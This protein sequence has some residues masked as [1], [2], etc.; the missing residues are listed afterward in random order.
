MGLDEAFDFEWFRLAATSLQRV[1]KFLRLDPA[2]ESKKHPRS[3]RTVGH[4]VRFVLREPLAEVPPGVLGPRMAL[5]GEIAA[6]EGVEVIEA[7]RKLAAKPSRKI[8][9]HR[10]ALLGQEKIQRDF[11]EPPTALE[12]EAVLRRNQFKRPSQIR[13][14][15]RESGE[16]LFHPLSAP[17][18]RLEPRPRPEPGP[19]RL[20]QTGAQVVAAHQGRLVRTLA[21]HDEIQPRE[22]LRLMRP[23]RRPV[24]EVEPFV[25]RLRF[26]R[27]TGA[28]VRDA[29]GPRAELD[30]VFRHV[31]VNE[32]SLPRR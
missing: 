31:H 11:E 25:H 19:R 30:F 18:S 24:G 22:Q 1:A 3:G 32:I 23:Q 13:R 10:V 26:G 20:R 7:D 2:L 8:S 6:G 16:M 9:E 12:G 28:E 27:L 14:L 15:G 29:A 21:V 17:W 4:V 5:H